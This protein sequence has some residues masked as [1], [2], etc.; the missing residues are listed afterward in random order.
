MNKR[1]SQKTY[2]PQQGASAFAGASKTR[3][4]TVKAFQAK[5]VRGF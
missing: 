1:S 4:I 3:N 5:I 2:T